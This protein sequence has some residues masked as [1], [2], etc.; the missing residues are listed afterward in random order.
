MCQR[1]KNPTKEQTTAEYRCSWSYVVTPLL[2][3][4]GFGWLLSAGI[5]FWLAVQCWSIN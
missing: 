1:D 5:G 4:S 3:I 2:Q